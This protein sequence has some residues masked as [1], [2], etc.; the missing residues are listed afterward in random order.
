MDGEQ[1]VA[2]VQKVILDSSFSEDDLLAF[3]NEGILAVAGEF[4]LP[5]L[6]TSST[7]AT[8]PGDASVIL[9]SDFHH[10][11]VE[12]YSVTQTKLLADNAELLKEW[13][14]FSRKYPGMAETGP[15]VDVNYHGGFL[16]YQPSPSTSETLLLHYYSLPTEIDY[17]D[18]PDCIPAQF[19]HSLLVNYA[20]LSAFRMIEDG[21]SGE[22]L[23]T[24][25]YEA[26]FERGKDELRKFLGPDDDMPDYIHDDVGWPQ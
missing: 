17:A 20:L 5:G 14:R 23:S 24:S 4:R 25:R 15:V 10:S 21:V 8:V 7:V 9:P 18:T 16:Y 19:H 2:R 13:R 22:G 1:L 12:V 6:F 3:I 26:L 11:L